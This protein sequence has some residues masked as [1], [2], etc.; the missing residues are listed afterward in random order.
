MNFAHIFKHCELILF[1]HDAVFL[2]QL[3]MQLDCLLQNPEG[4]YYDH[5]NCPLDPILSQCNPVHI[6][7]PLKMY[8]N[9]IFSCV[10]TSP[11]LSVNVIYLAKIYMYITLLP[12]FISCFFFGVFG[13]KNC[14]STHTSFIMT[15]QLSVWNNSR[16]TE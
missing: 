12:T 1:L 4:Q 2:R 15:V 14:K 5:G 11:R 8:L 16:T 9:V 3:F 13:I 7:F 10:S 6:S